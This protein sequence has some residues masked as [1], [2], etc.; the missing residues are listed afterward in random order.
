MFCLSEL[1]T[2]F[3]AVHLE[4][5]ENW[6]KFTQIWIKIH[7]NLTDAPAPFTHFWVGFGFDGNWEILNVHA[8][9]NPGLP[10]SPWSVSVCYYKGFFLLRIG[11]DRFE[12]LFKKI[13]IA[14]FNIWSK[15][16]CNSIKVVFHSGNFVCK[17]VKKRV[18]Q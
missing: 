16:I 4:F 1:S 18:W 2:P 14:Y 11:C 5:N 9:S 15:K 13:F 17:H 6:V 8:A 12:H 3:C 10:D 7:S